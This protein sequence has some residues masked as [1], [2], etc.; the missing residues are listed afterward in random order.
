MQDNNDHTVTTVNN[1]V[2]EEEEPTQQDSLKEDKKF[3]RKL[4][5]VPDW[6]DLSFS[7]I[8]QQPTTN[9]IKGGGIR[10]QVTEQGQGLLPTIGSK[11]KY[12]YAGYVIPSDD[13]DECKVP[14][15]L[16]DDGYSLQQV[17]LFKRNKLPFFEK[18]L[19]SMKQGEKS[20]FRIGADCCLID[21]SSLMALPNEHL[22]ELPE[23]Y[24]VSLLYYFEMVSLERKRPEPTHLDERIQYAQDDRI[25][26]N[27]HYKQQ[28]YKEAASCYGRAKMLLDSAKNV[29]S[30]EYPRLLEEQIKV[31]LNMIK[32]CLA[33]FE[34]LKEANN[35]KD[36]SKELE[37]ALVYCNYHP[38]QTHEPSIP[39]LFYLRAKILYCKMDYERARDF[40]DKSISLG[41]INDRSKTLKSYIDKKISFEKS[42]SDRNTK[43]TMS[44]MFDSEQEGL[45]S[46]AKPY[47]M[48]EEWERM[49]REDERLGRKVWFT[50]TGEEFYES[51]QRPNF[52]DVTHQ[53]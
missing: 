31:H 20:W 49:Q 39:E 51:I 2:S 45:Y 9:A 13:Q 17:R 36:A 34:Q 53:E 6:K 7:E 52:E 18:C 48:V 12:L 40:M 28:K 10:K 33:L 19:F 26:G 29:P 4:L 1:H 44:Q 38:L 3:E 23:D 43:K 47:D 25:L 8:L 41:Y 5:V 21:R 27:N 35:I 32:T 24:Q 11:I 50:N 22:Q 14:P 46:D 37:K 16:Y 15:V 30:S 42:K